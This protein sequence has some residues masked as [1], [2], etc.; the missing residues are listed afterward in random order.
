[1]KFLYL[2]YRYHY[3]S[4]VAFHITYSPAG[5]R[6]DLCNRY[7]GGGLGTECRPYVRGDAVITPPMCQLPTA[8]EVCR[9]VLHATTAGTR[10]VIRCHICQRYRS[11]RNGSQQVGG[12]GDRSWFAGIDA[13]NRPN[14][15]W[16]M[17]LSLQGQWTFLRRGLI[18]TWGTWGGIYK[19]L[20]FSRADDH[21]W[22][23]LHGWILVNPGKSW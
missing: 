8:N 3:F 13:L 9:G 2:F 18:I 23:Y 16:G 21:P 4:N 15:G 19:R 1:M 22:R 14:T 17:E 10:R 7:N 12:P 20:L 11:I 5:D 6:A